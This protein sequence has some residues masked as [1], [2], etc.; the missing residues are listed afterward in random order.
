MNS[1]LEDLQVSEKRPWGWMPNPMS[2]L[3]FSVTLMVSPSS[4]LKTGPGQIENDGRDVSRRQQTSAQSWN[5][6]RKNPVPVHTKEPQMFRMACLRFRGGEGIICVLFV[7]Y[8]V[9]LTSD[10]AVVSAKEPLRITVKR[11]GWTL[12]WV[13]WNTWLTLAVLDRA[14]SNSDEYLDKQ[15]MINIQIIECF[16]SECCCQTQKIHAEEWRGFAML[17]FYACNICWWN[18]NGVSL[19]KALPTCQAGWEACD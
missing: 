19:V 16:D 7:H 10:P 15:L 8:F 6:K 1:L 4:A 9:V 12:T 17:Y 2:A 11:C 14:V 18:W 5:G 3:F 13:K